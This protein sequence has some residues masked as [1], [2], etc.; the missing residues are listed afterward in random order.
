LRLICSTLLPSLASAWGRTSVLDWAVSNNAVRFDQES[1]SNAIDEASR[2]GHVEI[3]EWWKEKSGYPLA[4]SENALSSATIMRQIPILEWWKNSGL[5]LKIGLVL[6]FASMEGSTLT[7]DWWAA[8]AH[9]HPKYSKAALYHLSV[10]GNIACL[11]WWAKAATASENRFRLLY[12]KDVIIGA[13][14]HGKIAALQWWLDSGLEITYRGFD[15]EEAL[16]DAI[17]T[18]ART[19]SL[20]W[21]AKHGLIEDI[22]AVYMMKLQKF[23]GTFR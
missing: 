16:E 18:K 9:L 11:D 21:W 5:P 7:L 10:V 8:N 17:S 2:H 4:Y 20:L 3:L 19:A 22:D 15:I 14:K 1:I 6:D 12:D 13:T 23:P